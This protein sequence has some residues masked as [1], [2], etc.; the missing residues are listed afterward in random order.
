MERLARAKINLAL[1]VTGQRSD[2]YHLLD[3]LV[4]FAECGDVVSV[5]PA[6]E[7]SLSMEGVFADGLDVSR[8][9]LVLK[10]AYGLAKLAH[11]PNLGAKIHLRKE[12]PVASGIGGGSADAAATLGA[13]M[14][15]WDFTPDRAELF[16]LANSLG[17]DVPMCLSNQPCLARGVGDELTPVRLPAMNVV[18]VNPLKGVSTPAVFDRLANK[19]NLTLE[20]LPSFSDTASCIAYLKRQRNDL[21]ESALSFVPEINDCL[22]VL[23]QN[24]AHFAAMSG[25]GASCFGIFNDTIENTTQ[26]AQNIRT[27]HPNWWVTSTTTIA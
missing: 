21:L 5:Q 19:D 10:A 25:S 2:G 11:A 13:L 24:G 6:K 22:S 7:F 3:S 26:A 8:D 12:L 23:T 16:S 1:H 4:T 20:P 9:N 14:A 27:S 17:A 15:L 18:L